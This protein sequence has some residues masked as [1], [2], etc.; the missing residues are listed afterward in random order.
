MVSCFRVCEL[1]M[2]LSPSN[3]NPKG[4]ESPR[5]EAVVSD[6]ATRSPGREAWLATDSRASG[7]FDEFFSSWS[8]PSTRSFCLSLSSRAREAEASPLRLSAS[9]ASPLITPTLRFPFMGLRQACQVSLGSFQSMLLL[10]Q[11]H[12]LALQPFFLSLHSRFS[13]F[14]H[15]APVSESRGRCSRFRAH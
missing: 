15:F 6:V 8:R 9:S 11:R 13:F 1:P 12:L 14:D 3:D 4:S 5:S 2:L 10:F 7:C